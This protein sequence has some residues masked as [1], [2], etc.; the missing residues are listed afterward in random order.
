MNEDTEQFSE[1][2][3]SVLRS[4]YHKRLKKKGY[5]FQGTG[6]GGW[7]AYYKTGGGREAKIEFNHSNDT[8]GT[9]YRKRDSGQYEE[10]N[11]WERVDTYLEELM[12]GAK[13]DISYP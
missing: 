3:D 11:E 6:Q 7:T 4:K 1:L 13:P 10:G 2:P 8:H 12:E 5:K 9:L